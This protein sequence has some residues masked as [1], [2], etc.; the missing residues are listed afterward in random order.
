MTLQRVTITLPE[1]LLKITDEQAQS[2]RVNRSQY[3]TRALTAYTE[4]TAGMSIIPSYDPDHTKIINRMSDLERENSELKNKLIQSQRETISALSAL[5][6]GAPLIE[7]ES[8]T[9]KRSWWARLIG[10]D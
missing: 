8:S 5:T 10:R 3:F 9:P 7:A 6:S 2:E 1:E 4:G